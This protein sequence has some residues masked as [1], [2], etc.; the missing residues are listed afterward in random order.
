VTDPIEQAALRRKYPAGVKFNE[1]GFP[2]FSPYLYN[3]DPT[4]KNTVR[5]GMTGSY[6]ADYAEANRLA[7]FKDTPNGYV[8]HHNE[9]LGVMQLVPEDLHIGT[10]HSGGVT[11]WEAANGKS[12]GR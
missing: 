9:E 2:D 1:K 12:Y 5:I 7:G 4:K 8:W 10:R 11:L 3:A 6:R